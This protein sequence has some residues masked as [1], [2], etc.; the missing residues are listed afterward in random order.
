MLA[1]GSTPGPSAPSCPG[2]GDLFNNLFVPLPCC[3]ETPINVANFVKE[4][5]GYPFPDVVDYLV[6]GF[7]KG[8]S[9][10]YMASR[11][12]ITP[13]NLKSALDNE[14]HVTAAIIKEL[15]RK[16]IAG[17][18]LKPPINPFIASHRG[19]S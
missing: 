15:E 3:I 5:E 17:P 11:F 7:K 4:L 2:T 18:F 12:A 9:L 6:T 16:H 8:F 1:G 19:S 13:K 10:G 14:S